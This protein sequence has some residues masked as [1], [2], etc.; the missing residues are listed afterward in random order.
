MTYVLYA[1]SDRLDY[2][3]EPLQKR[4]INGIYTSWS[5]GGEIAYP[6]LGE[7]CGEGWFLIRD[8]VHH[9]AVGQFYNPGDFQ[10][11]AHQQSD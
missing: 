2:V 5:S 6:R 9:T 3:Y 1:D 7:S 11:L 4:R 10:S 8:R